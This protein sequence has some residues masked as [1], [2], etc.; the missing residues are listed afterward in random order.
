MPET[1]TLKG[2]V[3]LIT[4]A[5]SGIGA[6][7]A[8]LLASHGAR[9]VAADRDLQGARRTAA[10][11]DGHAIEMDVASEAD[12]KRTVEETV[13][14]FGGLDVLVN[15]AG[16][17]L[18][19]TIAETS[20]ADWKR[21]MSVN[22]DSVFLGTRAAIPAMKKGGSIVNISSVAGLNGYSKQA[23]YCASKGGVRL[24]TKASAVECAEAGLGIRVNSIHPGIIDTPMTQDIL[25]KVNPAMR[26]EIETRWKAMH[27]IGRLGRASDVAQCILFLA[28]D[29]SAFVTG[30]ELV[31]DGGL[32]AR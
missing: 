28:S 21:V 1:Q 30:A 31:V 11:T 27:P 26:S 19:K 20:L 32:T 25:G 6:E 15:C 29:A 10:E 2:K 5:A 14:T 12:W 7:A 4:G 3:V 22:L 18:V 24:F 13:A 23:A 8:R 16:I 9:A 17:E